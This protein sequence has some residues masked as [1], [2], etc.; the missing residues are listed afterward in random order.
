MAENLRNVPQAVAGRS[1][2]RAQ[3]QITAASAAGAKSVESPF[4]PKARATNARATTP[5]LNRL[6]IHSDSRLRPKS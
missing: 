4:E 6:P 1:S 5:K 3:F 2:K